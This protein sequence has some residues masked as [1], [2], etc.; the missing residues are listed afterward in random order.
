MKK[1]YGMM[2]VLCVM[3]LLALSSGVALGINATDANGTTT[4]SVTNTMTVTPTITDTSVVTDT[5]IA[6]TVTATEQP[7]ETAVPL[8]TKKSPGFEMVLTIG[9]LSVIYIFGKFRKRR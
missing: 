1:L 4:G 8:P 9:T 5:P 6:P 7:T 3:G 2:L